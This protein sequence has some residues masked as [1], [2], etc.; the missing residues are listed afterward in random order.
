MEGV[1]G[2]A[3]LI[4]AS[5]TIV[6]QQLQE[7]HPQPLSEFSLAIGRTLCNSRSTLNGPD[8]CNERRVLCAADLYST[9]NL[10]G[11]YLFKL[12]LNFPIVI[13]NG[14]GHSHSDCAICDSKLID[15][16][17]LR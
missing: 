13:K 5:E 17:A 10:N 12:M 3:S 2:E 15:V 11:W 7:T 16:S 6:S 1:L 4:F 8:L 9:M 14:G